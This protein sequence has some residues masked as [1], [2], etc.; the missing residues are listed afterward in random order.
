MKFKLILLLSF[1][2]LIWSCKTKEQDNTLNDLEKKEGWT[3]L[4]NGK[5]LT[6][7]HLYNAGSAEGS[8][9]RAENGQIIYSADSL[10]K[11]HEDLITDLSFKNYDLKFDWK[12]A[13]EGNSGVFINVTED[14]NIPTAWASG[15]EYQLL[16]IDHPDYMN[17]FKKR[18]G[19]L[20]GFL[21]QKNQVSPNNNGEWNHSRI[22]QNNGKTSF[23][24]NDVLTAEI[25]FESEDWKKM[26]AESK[27]SYFPDFGKTSE[28]KIAL[29]KWY[30]DVSFKNIKV[31]LL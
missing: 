21:E 25:G 10:N 2:F 22:V 5:D 20:Y 29:Q 18:P 28:G 26:I 17:D 12:V 16:D 6:G 13:K 23:Y 19:C 15:P 3:L 24:L 14:S 11:E 1:Q 27:F 30:G 4:F 31:K 9:W 7:W 8:A